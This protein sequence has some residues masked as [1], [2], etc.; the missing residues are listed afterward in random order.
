[1]IV[2][3]IVRSDDSKCTGCNRCVREC[4]VETANVTTQTDSGEIKVS[5]DGIK[6]ILCGRCIEACKHNARYYV[7]D[8]ERFF[9]DLK[10][11]ETISVIVAPSIKTNI[12]EYKRLFTCLKDLGVNLIYDVSMGADICIWA[13][14]KHIENNNVLPLITAPCPVIVSYC[15]KYNSTLLDRLA[16]VH[17]PMACTSIYLKKHMNLKDK[18]AALS[19]CLAKALE[20]E[21]TGIADYNVTFEKL[22][23]YF[24]DNNI[25]LPLDETSFDHDE[26]RLGS[27]FPMPGGLKENIEYLRGKAY[28]ITRSEGLHVYNDLEEYSQTPARFLPDIYD[29]LSC[30]DGCNLGPAYSHDRSMFEIGKTMYNTGK[31]AAFSI[32]R[33]HYTALHNEY[34]KTFDVADFTRKYEYA[35]LHL[36]TINNSDIEEAYMLLG[37][38]DFASQH[39][40]CSACGSDTCYKMARAIALKVN[41]PDNCLVKSKDDANMNHELNI[42]ALGQLA[43]YEKMHEADRRMMMVLDA[44]PHITL[45]FNSGFALFDCNPAAIEYF[46]T[47]TKE[48]LLNAFDER[49]NSYMPEFQPDGRRSSLKDRLTEVTKHGHAK[50]ELVLKVNG[51]TRYLNVDMKK[52]PYEKSFAIVAY[53]HDVTDAN[54]RESI[55]ALARQKAEAASKA[56]SMFLSNMS[57]EIRTPMSAIIGMSTIAEATDDVEKKEKAIS[58][59]KDAS[60]HLL[61]VINNILDMSKIEAEKLELSFAEFDFEDVL[62]KAVDLLNYRIEERKQKFSITLDKDIPKNLI[63]D[64][65]RLA[66]VIVNLLSNAVKFTPEGGK[67][68]L[69]AKLLPAESNDLCKLQI[70]VED[71]GIGLTDEQKERLFESFEQAEI[72]TSRKYG[73]TGL[74]LALSRNIVNMMDGDI[75]VESEPGSGAKFMFTVTLRCN[76]ELKRGAGKIDESALDSSDETEAVDDYTGKQVLLVEDMEINCEI[77]CA[78]LEPTNIS[79]DCAES[80][81]KALEMFKATPEKYDIIFMDIQMPGMDGY[82]T[83]R[84]IRKVDSPGAASIPIVAISANV[85][86]EDIEQCYD[87]GM[88]GHIGKPV[89]VEELFEQLKKYLK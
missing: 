43:A 18:I 34:E 51:D 16:P 10:N 70:S 58:R 87:A 37:K 62:E 17:S 26:S 74:G 73:G 14:I 2:I 39:I 80:G 68:H 23:K 6:C 54:E 22:L 3:D 59:I 27:L 41:I 55:L 33:G 46:K 84:C 72:D 44:N 78:L 49:M 60:V 50:F 4:P 57:H 56:K 89:Y 65:Q 25:I 42:A 88:N 1:M 30:G 64:E 20:F 40:D 11:G 38:P 66:Q 85:F 82:E 12:P 52:I 5:I 21:E 61:G 53:V 31:K 32:M 75:W 81:E 63:G 36:P 35:P 71:S 8:T 86:K 67:I 47:K 24:S 28:H 77:I 7:D 13:H 29:V 19:P 76:G 45:L 83:T 9:D 15:Q 48:E 79:I 69:E